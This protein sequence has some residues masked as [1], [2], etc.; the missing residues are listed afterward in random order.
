MV[1]L[2]I[3]ITCVSIKASNTYKSRY[4]VPQ[5]TP[6]NKVNYPNKELAVA[7]YCCPTMAE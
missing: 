7:L 6:G 4:N 3:D 5:D 2:R 1:K